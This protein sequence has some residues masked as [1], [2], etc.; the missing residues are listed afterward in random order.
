MNSNP[1]EVSFSAECLKRHLEQH[2][3]Q[4]PQLAIDHF[5]DFVLLARKYNE[6]EQ[7]HSDLLLEAA[8][9]L[10]HQQQTPSPQRTHFLT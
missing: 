2:P 5:T 1:L 7:K 3:E 8:M 10:Q 4:A 6:L 9:L